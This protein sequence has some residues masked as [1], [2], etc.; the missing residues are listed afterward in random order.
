MEHFSVTVN[1]EW[2]DSRF[3]K[4]GNYRRVLCVQY[5]KSGPF[6]FI[7]FYDREDHH[8]YN[9]RSDPSIMKNVILWAE[10]PVLPEG[11]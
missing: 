9:N 6:Y 7:G 10:L 11:Y 3:V 4:P 2:F 1:L 8:W 5:T